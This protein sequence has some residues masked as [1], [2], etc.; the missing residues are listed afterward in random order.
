[1]NLQENIS[2]KSYNTFGIEAKAKYFA[3]FES[4]PELE[5][6]H[7]YKLQTTNS[8][9]IL[10]GGSNILLTKDFDGIVLKNEIKGIEIVKED[11]DCV[12][13]KA[14]AG[15]NWHQFVLYCVRNNYAGIE[16]LSL[17]PGN[18]GAS[19]MQNIGAYGVEIKDVFYELEAFHKQ[20]KIVKKFSL[21][22]CAFG[23]RE[24]VFKNKY[25]EQFV[26]ANVTYRLNKK[27]SFNTS[28]GAINQE[29]ERMGVKELNI[30]A[31]SQAV[32]NIRSSK[33]PDPKEIGNAGSFFK[34]PVISNRQYLE[35]N[36]AFPNII[37]FPSG[38]DHTKLAA[39]WLIEQC[40]WKGYRKGDAGCYP[41]QALVLVNYGSASGKEVFDL[42]EE[43][44]QSVKK[45]FGVVLEREVNIIF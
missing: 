15:E 7:D 5:E 18:V 10:G 13:I 8:K 29:L 2:L 20:D 3:A 34:N 39:G 37:A 24:S 23:Y 35:L 11:D 1:M 4:L 27:P 19:P 16:N 30:Q 33:L 9:L 36:T 44:I 25:K 38:H 26:I 6:L 45:T 22:D 17:I 32:I 42:S 31:I 12:Y 40:G 21:E 41:K 43:I 28:Y 14:G